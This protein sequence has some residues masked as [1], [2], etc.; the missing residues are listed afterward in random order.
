[1]KFPLFTFVGPYCLAIVFL[2]SSFGRAD[3]RPE[4]LYAEF[5]TSHGSFTCHLDYVRAPRTVANFVRLANGTKKWLDYSR[6]KVVQEP[7]YDGLTFH[8]VVKGFVIQSGSPRGTGTDD[9]GYRFRDEFHPELRHDAAGVLSMANS[10]PDTN[11]SQFFITLAAT[12]ALNNVHSV[13]GRIVEGLDVVQA[14]GDVQ[15]GERDKPLDPVTIDSLTIL[16]VGGEASAFDAMN[17]EPPLP[18]PRVVEAAVFN[19]ENRWVIAWPGKEG[20]D[21][22]M[23]FT[24]DFSVW[25]GQFIGQFIG[26]RIEDFMGTFDHQFFRA[27]ET[28]LDE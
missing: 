19:T 8:R 27:F 2:G 24:A 10:G 9:P 11:G 13:F 28:P 14:I 26:R 20:M 16:A 17:V 5:Q 21:Y 12:P 18:D 25:N 6:G 3:E 23:T 15:V 1:M 22:R 4:G 7:F